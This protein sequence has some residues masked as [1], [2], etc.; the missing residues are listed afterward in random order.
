[1]ITPQSA[2]S[3]LIR[4]ENVFRPAFFEERDY[5]L[6][7]TIHLEHDIVAGDHLDDDEVLDLL[8]PVLKYATGVDADRAAACVEQCS[9][10]YIPDSDE[11]L[12]AALANLRALHRDCVI[13]GAWLPIRSVRILPL[14]LDTTRPDYRPL[15]A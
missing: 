3:R 12:K 15:P 10:G 8:P 13:I 9:V 11:Y 14:L 5:A 6:R 4:A 7:V 2:G 1:M